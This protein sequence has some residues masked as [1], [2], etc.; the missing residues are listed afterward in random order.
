MRIY[1]VRHAIAEDTPKRGGGDA[2]RALTSEGRKKMK[3][4]AAGFVQ[5]NTSVDAI[6][7]SPLVRARQTADIVAGLLKKE[8]NEMAELSPGHSPADV[9]QRLREKSKLEN[10]MLVGHEPNCSQLASY[11][12]SETVKIE[13][14]FK[15]GGICLIESER[16]GPG[17]GLLLWLATPQI[18]RS[19]NATSD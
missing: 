14:Q 8:V 15:K 7:S 11:L 4:V 10:V 2:Q 9:V 13:M 19:M 5:L 1:I 17:D 6:F 18:L 12:L 3:E 16:L